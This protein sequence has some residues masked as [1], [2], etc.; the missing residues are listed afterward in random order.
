[1]GK[2]IEITARDQFKNENYV[3]YPDGK[4]K[5]VIVVIQEIFGVNAHIKA[6]ADNY[7]FAWIFSNCTCCL[8]SY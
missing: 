3:A 4:P 7:A 2:I 1:M 8:L 5:A 6:V